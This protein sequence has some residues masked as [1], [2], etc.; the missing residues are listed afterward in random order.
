MEY[1]IVLGALQVAVQQL[2]VYEGLHVRS[3]YSREVSTC[4]CA[5]GMC[6]YQSVGR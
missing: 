1:A 2:A 5:Y 4:V 3:T 6:V